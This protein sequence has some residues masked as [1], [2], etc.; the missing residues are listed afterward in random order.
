MIPSTVQHG[1]ELICSYEACRNAGIKFRY[2]ASC[3]IP[4]AKRNFNQ[5]HSHGLSHV[6]T[7]HATWSNV[8]DA[9]VAAAAVAATFGDEL[10]NAP[11]AASSNDNVAAARAPAG[12]KASN[13]GERADTIT[14]PRRREHQAEQDKSSPSSAPPPVV[15]KE[16]PGSDESSSAKMRKRTRISVFSGD[17]GT[18]EKAEKRSS[19]NNKRKKSKSDPPI[20]LLLEP[21]PDMPLD[22]QWRWSSLLASRPDMADS[23][24]MSAWLLEV[25]AVS[26]VKC[27]L[28]DPITSNLSHSSGDFSSSAG[29]NHR[30]QARLSST[31]SRDDDESTSSLT[32]S[33]LAGV[34]DSADTEHDEESPNKKKDKK[35]KKKRKKSHSKKSKRSEEDKQELSATFAEWKERKRRK[36]EDAARQQHD[37]SSS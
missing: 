1:E 11:P 6:S 32:S 15:D 18:A 35:K 25:M 31:R 20:P 9:P 37:S 19:S 23:D 12:A 34:E 4:V 24:R 27:P 22:R 10:S 13:A 17:I 3:R 14:H 29:S 33:P 36:S 16:S 28:R 8:V 5:R 21:N 26:D 30:L 7:I 2:C